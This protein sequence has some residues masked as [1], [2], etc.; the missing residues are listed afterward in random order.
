MGLSTCSRSFNPDGDSGACDLAIDYEH[1][2]QLLSK[3]WSRVAAGS[4]NV[5][6]VDP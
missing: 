2:N 6:M 5:E 1:M 3:D 4:S